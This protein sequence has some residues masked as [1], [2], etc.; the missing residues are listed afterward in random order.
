MLTGYYQFCIERQLG[1]VSH[2]Q[3]RLKLA[4]FSIHTASPHPI[5]LEIQTP[6][7]MEFYHFWFLHCVQ[8]T[9]YIWSVGVAGIKI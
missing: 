5:L 6:V 4:N 3:F 1:H 8:L 9:N 7:T 2:G